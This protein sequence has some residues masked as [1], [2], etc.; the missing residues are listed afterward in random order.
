GGRRGCG[1]GEA[2]RGRGA[3]VTLIAGPVNLPPPENVE[4]INVRSTRD[5]FEAVMSRIHDVTVFI[6]SAAVADFRPASRAA[7]K[8]KKDGRKTISIE[9]EETEDIIAAVGA[10]PN[11]QGRIVAGFAAESQSLLES[12]EP[13]LPAKGLDL[14]VTNHTTRADAG[15]DVETNAA[16]I[17]KRDGSRVELSLQSKRELAD[18]LLD[19]IVWIREKNSK[20]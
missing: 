3:R 8:I 14:I 1:V 16:T 6:G 15:F 17:L 19:E 9:L 18:R 7:Q 20:N 4:T 13:E 12:A 11:R 10:D 2:A 5:M